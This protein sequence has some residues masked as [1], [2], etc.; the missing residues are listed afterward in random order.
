[1]M[2]TKRGCDFS[3]CVLEVKLF[4]LKM[5]KNKK[6]EIIVCVQWK[7]KYNKMKELLTYGVSQGQR[8]GLI[9]WGP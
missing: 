5:K 3:P 7:L 1:M 8:S 2:S 4:T 6:K 9:Y